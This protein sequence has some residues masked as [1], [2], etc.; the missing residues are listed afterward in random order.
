[1]MKTNNWVIPFLNKSKN[2]E[3]ALFQKKYLEEIE[4]YLPKFL[5]KYYSFEN[6]Y[7]ITNLMNDIIYL[8]S[9][10]VFNDPFDCNFA[11]NENSDMIRLNIIN[12]PNSE[13]QNILHD[14][15]DSSRNIVNERTLVSCFSE[16]SKNL[17]M[18]SHY[19]NKHTGF[20]VEYDISNMDNIYKLNLFPILYKTERPEITKIIE[21]G[22]NSVAALYGAL[23]TK[24]KI[25]KYEKEWRLILLPEC[26]NEN[27][28]KQDIVSKVFCGIKTSADNIQKLNEI[29]E[30]KNRNRNEN[31]QIKLKQ[32]EADEI[33]YTIKLKK[34]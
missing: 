15:K 9:P 33:K 24:C 10:N 34:K 21:T 3:N 8:S 1:M 5:Y 30:N 11:Y 32:Y 14:A 18:W 17:L 13:L 16:T 20:C 28:I 22:K 27:Y 4:S 29:I 6:R 12:K 7:S 26:I 2:A 19:A 31:N 23:L 25:W